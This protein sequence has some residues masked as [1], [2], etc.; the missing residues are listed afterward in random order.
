MKISIFWPDILHYHA[1]RLNALYNLAALKGDSVCAYSFKDKASYSTIAS[2]D[3]LV[4]DKI[5]ILPSRTGK[6]GLNSIYL[7]DKLLEQL[8]IDEPDVVAILGYHTLV[9]RAAL[10]WCRCNKKGAILMVASQEVDKPR[11]FW[12]ESIKKQIVPLY[13]AAIVGGNSNI[14]YI[15]KLG[16]P[17]DRIFTK[18]DVVDNNFWS[19][20][21]CLSLAEVNETK[22]RFQIADD[23]FLVVARL[24]PEKNLDFF[25]TVYADYVKASKHPW[26]LVIVGDGE[27]RKDLEETSYNLQINEKVHFLGSLISEDLV[28]IYSIASVLVLPSISEPWGLVVNE[29]MLSG[30]PALV[31]NRCGCSKELIIEGKTGFTFDPY[32]KEYLISLLE[33]CSGGEVDC[34]EMGINAKK[35]IQSYSPE[36]FADNLIK[37][38]QCAIAYSETR[39]WNLWPKPQLWL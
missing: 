39:R 37:A 18:Y 7:R 13:D 20:H 6:D 26:H 31:S 16:L 14:Q 34:M 30:I 38:A 28:K 25:L 27:L 10:A 24:I 21:S 15:K 22:K 1:A 33:K 11:V 2:Y 4:K 12:K 5:T 17:E 29:A 32:D 19:E 9:S 8:N 35:H 36:A 23:F 3:H